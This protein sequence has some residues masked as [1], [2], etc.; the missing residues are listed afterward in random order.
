MVPVQQKSILASTLGL[1][2]LQVPL[3]EVENPPCG[4]VTGESEH[5]FSELR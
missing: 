5:P 1:K 4:G 3:A 2:S